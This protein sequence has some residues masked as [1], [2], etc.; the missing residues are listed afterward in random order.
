MKK[1]IYIGAGMDT[2]PLFC[3]P[4]IKKWI[5][6]DSRPN[7]EFGPKFNTYFYDSHFIN[8]VVNCFDLINFN[9]LDEKEDFIL[10]INYQTGQEV[11]YYVNT[12]LPNSYLKIKEKIL[13]WDTL[14][15]AG[16]I[17][18]SCCMDSVT[19]EIPTTFIGFN[20]TYYLDALDEDHEYTTVKSGLYTGQ[21]KFDKYILNYTPGFYN[22]YQKYESTSEKSD[23]WLFNFLSGRISK[24]D[25]NIIK[26]IQEIFKTHIFD[27]FH[28]DSWELFL[29]FIKMK[30]S[31]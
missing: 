27:S 17:P 21:Y 12:Y 14:V 24:M 5:Y 28:F 30:I 19:T 16:H 4:K 11:E 25:H 26:K 18:S 13:G 7:N 3:F 20:N 31:L 10:F 1:A 8:D 23:E 22:L 29:K 15:V 2:R 6:I 9:I